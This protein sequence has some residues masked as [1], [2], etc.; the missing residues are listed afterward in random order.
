MKYFNGRG[1]NKEFV[2]NFYKVIK[3]LENNPI[4]KVINYPDIIC[5]SCPHNVNNKCI[6]KGP[7]FENKVREKDNI[8]MKC[9]GI[10]PNKIIK[11]KDFANLVSLRLNKLREICKDCEWKQYCD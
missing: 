5:G 7:D 4:I 6:K 2:S 3:K 1:Y 11:V 10:K 8:V 9:L